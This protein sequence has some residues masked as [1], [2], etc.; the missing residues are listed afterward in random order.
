MFCFFFLMSRRT[1]RSTRTDTL[2]PDTTLF[3]RPR[4]AG[5]VAAGGGLRHH[6]ADVRPVAV[7][8]RAD[9]GAWAVRRERDH[10]GGDGGLGRD[11][12]AGRVPDG[13]E[14]LD[15]KS[16]GSGKSGAVRVGPG[17][18][19]IIKKKNNNN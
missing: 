5:R 11:G 17:S 1:P 12:D 3:R 8:L 7:L 10:T 16:V 15:R 6:C 19:C 14:E 18:R 13:D 9:M 2:F 4:R